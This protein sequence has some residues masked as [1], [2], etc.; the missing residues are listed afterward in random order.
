VEEDVV[1]VLT[2]VSGNDVGKTR[3]ISRGGHVSIGRS[4]SS[5]FQIVDDGV[6]RR[7]CS[8][9]NKG[10]RVVLRDEDS[11][12]GTFVNGSKVSAGLL[13]SGDEIR[14]GRAVLNVGMKG[15]GSGKV[16][17]QSSLNL[18]QESPT[19]EFQQRVVRIDQTR[20][21]ATIPEISSEQASE[22]LQAHAGLQALYKVGS[23]INVAEDLDE[24][25][26]TVVDSVLEI[27]GVERAAL[28]VRDPDTGSIE[29]V[30]VQCVG[31]RSGSKIRVSRT[32]VD[33]VINDGV[34]AISNNALEDPRFKGDSI[35]DQNINAI[36][37]VPVT[38]KDAVLGALYVDTTLVTHVFGDTDLE[39][40][41][42]IGFQA[43]VAIERA[44]LVSGL[45]NLF[46]GANRALVAA[47]EA[48]DPY[49]HGHS[50]RVTAMSLTMADVMGLSDRE[51]EI[52]E[53]SGLLHD[54]GKIGVPEAVLNKPDSLNDSEFRRIKLHPVHGAEIIRNIRHQYIEEVV[55]AVR[56]HHERWDGEGYPN[57]LAGDRICLTS[58]LLAVADTYD[59][60]TSDRPYRKGMESDIAIG[61]LHE[62]AG[63]QLDKDMV[64]VFLTAHSDGTIQKLITT[65][66]TWKSKYIGTRGIWSV[67]DREFDPRQ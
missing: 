19:D 55:E 18:V 52:V 14:L 66:S 38:G 60:M 53:L 65:Q 15:I 59:A 44:R 47:V 17:R 21:M 29:P 32:V 9:E 16:R 20:L 11:S 56:H 30:A 26:E 43:G 5:M 34:S 23:S 50:E 57:G 39:I 7:H 24:L 48:R 25:Y 35:S 22:M 12:N 3:E 41:A 51:C 28:I 27:G 45:E 58:R 64:R 13:S 1:V 4:S 54:V 49:T 10:N 42:A 61:I 46:I 67:T 6:S 8:I 37:C 62:V 31:D 33:H 36:M 2:V 40:L 63:T